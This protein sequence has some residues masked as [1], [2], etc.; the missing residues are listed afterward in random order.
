MA[1]VRSDLDF[2]LLIE[3]IVDPQVNVASPVSLLYDG[4]NVGD[5]SFIHLS[6]C[7]GICVALH[8]SQVIE[9]GVIVVWVCLE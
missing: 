6:D 2:Q 7:V 9:P 5:G 8:Q 4:G 3:S 1:G